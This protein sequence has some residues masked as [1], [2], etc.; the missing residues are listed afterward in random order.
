MYVLGTLGP[1]GGSSRVPVSTS[2]PLPVT[3]GGLGVPPVDWSIAA[4]ALPAG[5][6]LLKTVLA[7][8]LRREIGVQNQG[9]QA[10]VV[11]RGA[12]PTGSTGY[13][14]SF[15]N[16][17]LEGSTGTTGAVAFQSWRSE[18]FKGQLQVFGA[19]GAGVSVAA[20]YED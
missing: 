15:T 17:V 1:N 13:T 8:P 5:Y 2:N 20:V 16:W 9:I 19:T 18:T 14:G 6:T 7:N 3:L 12:G 10:L 11:V 4:P